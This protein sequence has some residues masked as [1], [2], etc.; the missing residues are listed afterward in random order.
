MFP[1]RGTER[2]AFRTPHGVSWFPL[3]AEGVRGVAMPC[4]VLLPPASVA[5]HVSTTPSTVG[6]RLSHGARRGPAVPLVGTA[7]TSD[8]YLLERLRGR[9][10]ERGASA[11]EFALVVP[12]LLLIVFGIIVYGMVFA[13]SL[14]LSNSARQAARSGVIS[15][16]TCDQ[17]TT[18]A[19][20]AADTI[21]MNGADTTVTVKRGLSK[22]TAAS[23]CAGGGTTQPCK[24]QA[25]GTNVYVTLTYDTDPIVPFVPVPSTLTGGGVFR[26]EFQ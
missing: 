26:C 20:D 16:T 18:L 1:F 12:F 5:G 13:Q 11:V 3:S 24:S 23:A 10:D 7:G 15:G 4:G 22:S 8:A 19:H 17:I 21:G 6:P 14:S 25:V 2:R 9:G